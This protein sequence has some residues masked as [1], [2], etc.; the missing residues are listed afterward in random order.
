MQNTI[1]LQELLQLLLRKIW[2]ILASS[3]LG[4]VVFF[5]YT[6]LFMDPQY[7]SNVQF[8][9]SSKQNNDSSSVNTDYFNSSQK[10]VNTYSVILKSN[11]VLGLVID[12]LG[13]DITPEEL[14]DMLNIYAVNN[15]EAMIVEVTTHDPDFSAKIANTIANVAPD[16]IKEITQAGY[17]TLV[18]SAYPETTP[19][20]PK[21]LKNALIGFII[22]LALSIGI[23]ILQML[24]D[25][26]VKDEEDIKKYYNI[27]VLGGIPNF[28]TIPKGG[29]ERYEY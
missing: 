24:F 20:S 14:K 10:L 28:H 22:G 12:T 4:L 17:I 26:H 3:V 18:D 11:R 7:T 25:V 29:Y 27:P 19:S 9:V 8:Y 1:G 16:Q 15:T 23:V 13:S 6:K 2:I 21:P 5:G